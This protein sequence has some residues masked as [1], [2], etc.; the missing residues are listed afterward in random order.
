VNTVRAAA[1]LQIITAFSAAWTLLLV[2]P[3]LYWQVTSW[4]R[5]GEWSP[6]PISKV[7]ALAGFNRPATYNTAS[8]LDSSDAS[9]PDGQGIFVRLLDFPTIGLLLAVAAI[10]LTFSIWAASIQ[11]QFT[12]VDK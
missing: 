12:A 11:K 6:F 7:L 9:L 10:L 4:I 2:L 8:I 3:V 5:N 1:F